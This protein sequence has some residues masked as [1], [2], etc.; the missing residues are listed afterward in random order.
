MAIIQDI[1]AKILIQVGDME[2]QEIGTIDIPI[3]VSS[4]GKTGISFPPGVRAA[5]DGP[6]S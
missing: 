1:K 3:D 5:F 4:P 2:P 6:K